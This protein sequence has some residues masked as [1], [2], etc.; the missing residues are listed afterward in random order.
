[1]EDLP[2]YFRH[3]CKNIQ[4]PNK[5]DK[6]GEDGWVATSSLIVVADGVSAWIEERI[7]PSLFSK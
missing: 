4:H 1:M 3:G 7:D 5:A 6:G 2:Y